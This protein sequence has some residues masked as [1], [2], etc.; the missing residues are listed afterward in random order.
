VTSSMNELLLKEFTLDEVGVALNQ[1]AP[2]KPPGPDGFSA[3]FYQK[4]WGDIG[5]EVSRAVID[6]LN[7]GNLNKELNLTYIVLIPKNSNPTCVTEY[8]PISLC[9]VFYKLILKTLANRLKMVLNEIISPNQSAFI[10]S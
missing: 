4:N 5:V 7:N 8:R 2:N 1:M 9:N 10:P 3:D 6:V